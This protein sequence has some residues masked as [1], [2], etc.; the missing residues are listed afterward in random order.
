MILTLHFI[1]S[2]FWFSMCFFLENGKCEDIKIRLIITQFSVLWANIEQIL[3]RI[4][5]FYYYVF[6]SAAFFVFHQVGDSIGK[7]REALEIGRLF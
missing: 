1:I 2:E 6:F 4:S 3:G 7:K 5:P